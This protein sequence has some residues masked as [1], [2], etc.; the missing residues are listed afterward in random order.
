[1]RAV[2]RVVFVFV[3]VTLDDR[4]VVVFFGFYVRW[5]SVILFIVIN[6]R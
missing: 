3:V 5:P 4:A 6:R 1:M 2:V